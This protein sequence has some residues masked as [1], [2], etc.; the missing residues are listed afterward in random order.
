M[1][2]DLPFSPMRTIQLLGGTA[3][4]KRL[5]HESQLTL[6][7]YPED[8]VES[9]T[10]LQGEGEVPVPPNVGWTWVV[11]DKGLRSLRFSWDRGGERGAMTTSPLPGNNKVY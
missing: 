10:N 7:L 9:I 8:K 1:K 11:V 2:G 4:D 6:T 5:H 3:G